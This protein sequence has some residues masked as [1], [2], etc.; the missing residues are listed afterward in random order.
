MASRID[1]IKEIV[2]EGIID[3][4]T[5]G[6]VHTHGM[7]KFGKPELEMRNVPLFLVGQATHLINQVCDYIL[8]SG[9]KVQAGEVFQMGPSIFRLH[10]ASPIDPDDKALVELHYRT[11]RWIFVEMQHECA[12]CGPGGVRDAHAARA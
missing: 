5:K 1:V 7:A 12:A 6:W 10:E 9:K 3:G 8:N 11:P 4:N 2:V